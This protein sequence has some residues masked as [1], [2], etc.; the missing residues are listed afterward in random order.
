[1]SAIG[2]ALSVLN[3][4]AG[5][6]WVDRMGLKQP[7]EALAYR[8]ARNGLAAGAAA[9]RRFGA[10]RRLAATETTPVRPG[11]A[12]DAFDLNIS[13][14][15][16]MIKDSAQ[17]LARE[18]MR[19]AAM[20]ADAAR[21]ASAELRAKL[22]ELALSHYAVPESLGGNGAALSPVTSVIVAEA[23]GYGDMGLAVAALASVGVVNAL[24]RWGSTAQKEAYLP[25]FLEDDAPAA[26]LVLLEPQP[27]FEPYLLATR[28]RT[29]GSGFLLRGTKSL[30]PLAGTAELFLIGAELEG[31]GPE[32]FVVERSARGLT[33][34]PDPA[35]G[36]RAADLGRLELDDV[37][38]ASDALLGGEAGACRYQEL[39]DLS[40]IAWC[41]LATG[42][43]QAVLEY[44]I[45]YCNA[46]VAFGEP[47]SH[48]QAVAFTIAN[49]AIEVD[50]MRLLTLRAA[51][52]AEHGLDFHDE[53]Y[54][55]RLFAAE[56]AM[57]IGTNGI[58][59]LG[60][61]GFI[62]EHPVERWYRD[63]RAVGIMEGGLLA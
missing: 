18:S 25:A 60:G 13:D 17:R 48:R 36:L 35:M 1:M 37:H 31:K 22:A 27:L 43:A 54:L 49:I 61:H 11:P 50:A 4:V 56:K 2:R 20:E 39:V 40:R 57:E 9:S 3:R 58:Q 41:G 46:R 28:A 6:T 34:N 5:S 30:V 52:R 14:E 10:I 63:L 8:A 38:V 44:V 47:I 16:Q 62:K 19:P 15:Q 21:A 45:E 59:L 53:A 32:I 29:N 7:V 12:P 23:L 24:V 42:T 55:A 51:S 33:V 26:S